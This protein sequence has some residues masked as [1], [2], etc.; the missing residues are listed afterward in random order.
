MCSPFCLLTA[1]LCLVLQPALALF[2]AG[3]LRAKHSLSIGMQVFCGVIVLSFMY[4]MN[5]CPLCMSRNCM[6]LI[7]S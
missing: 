3:L 2:E 7:L 6:S 4:D 1:D 5:V